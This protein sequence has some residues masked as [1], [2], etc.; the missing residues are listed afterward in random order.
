MR[1]F[2]FKKGDI[3]VAGILLVIIILLFI[4]WLI[5]VGGRECRNNR[6]CGDGYYCGS[7]YACHQVPSYQQRDVD[8][9]SFTMPALILGVCLIITALILKWDKIKAR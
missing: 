5:N 7:D 3:T 6:D 4:G 1:L 9:G 2:K 8:G